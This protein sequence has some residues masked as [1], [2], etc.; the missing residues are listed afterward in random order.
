[1]SN[2][3]CELMYFLVFV[4]VVYRML[5]WLGL[6]HWVSNTSKEYIMKTV[7]EDQQVSSK[8]QHEESVATGRLS[9]W[10]HRTVQCHIIG[11]SDAPGNSSLTASSW[12]HYGGDPPDCLVQDWH[13]ATVTCN[14]Q[15]QQLVAHQIG[16]RAVRCATEKHQLFSNG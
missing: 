15:I 9:G 4:F 10:E 12:W 1:M 5:K 14:G 3:T 6:K 8:V 7:S 16:H 11:L 13:V 2:I